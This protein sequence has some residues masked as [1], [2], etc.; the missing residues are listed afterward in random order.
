LFIA[1]IG[2][3]V[4]Q[5]ANPI[6]GSFIIERRQIS[7]HDGLKVFHWIIRLLGYT[8]H[9]CMF[10]I[11]VC[12]WACVHAYTRRVDTPAPRTVLVRGVT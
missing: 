10:V 1:E 8:Y 3:E 2:C 5:L 6:S 7:R 4:D 12:V 9:G 11:M